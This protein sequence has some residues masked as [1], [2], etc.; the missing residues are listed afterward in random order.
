MR[1]PR[2]RRLTSLARPAPNVNP[3]YR[4]MTL[5]TALLIVC[6][7]TAALS[8]FGTAYYLWTTRWDTRAVPHVLSEAD[9]GIQAIR[10]EHDSNGDLTVN[11]NDSNEK[12]LSYLPH[13]GFHNQRIAFENAL[14]LSRLLNRTLLVPPVRLGTRPFPYVRFDVLRKRLAF[15]KEDMHLC[16]RVPADVPTPPE[17]FPWTNIPW[18]GLVNLSHVRSQQ[19]LLHV[20]NIT[21]EWI[22]DRF[23]LAQAD[24][25]TLADSHLYDYRFLDSA[26]GTLPW[27][28]KYRETVNIYQLALRPERLLQIG[29]LFGTSR[30]R[31]RR[32]ENIRIRGDIRGS[33]AFTEPHLVQ[34]ADAIS[35]RL[36]R[37]YLGAHIRQ[38]DGHFKLNR[39]AN[40]RLAWWKMVSHVLKISVNETTHLQHRVRTMSPDTFP[41]RPQTPEDATAL[42]VS[43]HPFPPLPGNSSLLLPCRGSKH[44]TTLMKPLNIPLFIS[45]DVKHPLEDPGIAIFLNTFPCTFFLS[46]FRDLTAPLD[47]LRNEEDGV[48]LKQYFLPFLDAMVVG[49]AWA[50]VGTEGSTFSQFIQDVLW[51]TYHGW[52][53]F[54]RG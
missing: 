45:T 14:V 44:T 51:R 54:Q 46:D 37:I 3:A 34:A 7:A 27:D 4:G 35:K 41:Q 53:I 6:L 20:P 16:T 49:K 33:M 42:A 28:H 21:H 5:C 13:S 9:Q 18:E 48:R 1:A 11:V 47:K 8:S 43:H 38:G 52:Q 24:I 2:T 23:Q 12:L 40:A 19:P 31:L 25:F 30:L 29:T 36:G 17:C 32:A 10:L 22:R 26:A 15:R 50:V 39:Y